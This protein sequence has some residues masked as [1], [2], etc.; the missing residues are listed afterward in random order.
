MKAFFEKLTGGDDNEVEFETHMGGDAETYEQWVEPEEDE[1]LAVDVYQ[2]Q[3][4]LYVKTFIPGVAP[5]TLD[6]DITRDMITV[7]GQKFKET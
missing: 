3:D 6:I 1:E 4:N 2:D 7:R 5:Q